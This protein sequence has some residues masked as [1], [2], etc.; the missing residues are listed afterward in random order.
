MIGWP[1]PSSKPTVCSGERLQLGADMLSRIKPVAWPLI[2]SIAAISFSPLLMLSTG[3]ENLYVLWI[4]VLMAALWIAQRLTK[5]EVGVA[6]GDS[7]SYLAAFAYPTVIIG[8]VILGAWAEQLFDLK[9]FMWSTVFRRISLNFLLTFVLALIT[10]EGFFRGALWGSCE[11]AGFSPA[12]TIIWTSLAFGLWHIAV[13]LV[14]PEFTQPLI[15][16]PQYAIGSTIFAVAMG[17]LR[18]RSGS[19]VVTSACHALWNATVYTLFGAG[20]KAGQLGITDTSL[21]D[22]ERGYAGLALAALAAIL[23]WRWIKPA[24]A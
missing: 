15:K 10:E 23:L 22:P 19:V 13:P 17:A 18:L 21:W 24:K 11:R 1:S 16:V 5:R 9:D 8:C 20:E 3:E 2:A 7:K 14:D 6:L 12:K 4:A